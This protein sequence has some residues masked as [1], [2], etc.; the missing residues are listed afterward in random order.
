MLDIAPC[1]LAEVVIDVHIAS[2]ILLR[3]DTEY[4]LAG[5]A[6][7]DGRRFAIL[8]QDDAFLEVNVNRVAPPA[9]GFEPPY[10]GGAVAGESCL[11]G[12]CRKLRRRAQPARVGRVGTAAVGLDRPRR[13]V[14][15]GRTAERECAVTGIRERRHL[16]RVVPVEHQRNH[17][18]ATRLVFFGVHAGVHVGRVLT[19]DKF[20]ELADNGIA[21]D[22]ARGL[23]VFK[24]EFRLV[25][26][27]EHGTE[28]DDALDDL[29]FLVFKNVYEV[30]LVARLQ[31]M[32]G[33]ID[34]DV[35]ALRDRLNGQNA[36]VLIG[37]AVV[38]EVVEPVE[39]NRMLHDVAVVR[40][41]VERNA[42]PGYALG[43][44]PP[45]LTFP[46]ALYLLNQRQ[47]KI[48]SNGAVQD[49]KPVLPL[50]DVEVGLVQ[51][52]DEHPVAQEA[53]FIEDV[54][55]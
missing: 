6:V 21:V 44:P 18:H 17:L 39:W 33:E 1:E 27:P 32:G 9:A 51:P 35:I 30:Q 34:N 38:I 36:L 48:A 19:H 29:A 26:L 20:E 52:V 43:P 3:A 10:F 4:V 25:G 8:V 40:D 2:S 15:T 16:F 49:S 24:L 7:P 37:I 45:D 42:V 5:V 22:P 55:P 47:L 53:V 28:I 13:R 46:V 31:A 23:A 50:P 12:A 54:E 14:G 41:Q 11:G